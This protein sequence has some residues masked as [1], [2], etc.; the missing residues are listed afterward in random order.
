MTIRE[1]LELREIEYLSPYATLSKD[2]RGRDRAEE[3]C[4]IR[5]VFQRD[6]DRILHCKAFRRLKQK[7]QVFLLPKGDHYRTRLTHTLEVSQNARTIAKA[8]RLNEDLVEAIALGHDLG[9]TPFGHA[10]ERAL[11][12]VCPLG[13][14]HNEQSVRVV[15]RL[16]KQGEGLNLTWEVRDGILNHKSAGTPHTLE[17]QI[18]RLSDK[19]AYINHDI[20]DAIRGGVL[21]EEDIPKPYREI[22]GN[23]TRVRLDTMIHNV[24][25]NSMDQPEI[26][27]SPEVERATMDLRAFMF[28]NVYKNPVAKGEEEKAINM[29]TNLYDYYRRHIQLLP[30]QF[31]EM[32]EEEGGT[33]ERIVCDYIAGMTDTYAIKKFEEYFIPE[34]WKI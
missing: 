3:E 17:G 30:D 20:D 21:K 12:E 6:R 9:H 32:L 4:D 2:S 29:V 5:P 28:E 8:L 10:G 22:L 1:Q 11:D 33:P 13:F 16:E 34:S 31:L 18:V 25:I 19:I 7:T 24:I 15:E 23:S 27:M 14:Q 26:R